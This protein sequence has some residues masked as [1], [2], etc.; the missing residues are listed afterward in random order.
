MRRQYLATKPFQKENLGI[1]LSSIRTVTVDGA[2]GAGLLAVTLDLLAATLV[3][4][5][6]D[7]SAFL[8][9]LRRRRFAVGGHL[10]VLDIGLD[11]LGRRRG[12]LDGP[13]AG[14][15]RLDGGRLVVG[16]VGGE[17]YGVCGG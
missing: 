17:R 11:A 16:H 10:L 7:S 14:G 4:S 9:G 2:V 13:V 12:I 5:A 6:G 15:L 1:L 3:A 8:D